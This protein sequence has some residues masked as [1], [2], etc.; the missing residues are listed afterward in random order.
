MTSPAPPTRRTG[1][2]VLGGFLS[3]AMAAASVGLVA[4]PASAADS[5]PEDGVIHVLVTVEEGITF[6]S[7]TEDIHL[8]GAPG[9]NVDNSHYPASFNVLTNSINGYDVTVRSQSSVMEPVDPLVNSHRIPISA[10]SVN[11]GNSYVPL[12]T[13]AQTVWTQ[14]TPSANLGDNRDHDFNL[15]IPSVKAADY[16]VTLEYIASTK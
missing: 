1:R 13:D 3:L 9:E 15:D 11:D 7:T 5:L 4:G 8:E 12:T 6:S 2:L 10:L 14:D 16:S